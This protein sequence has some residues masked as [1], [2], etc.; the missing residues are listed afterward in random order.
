MS[1]LAI[2]SRFVTPAAVGLALLTTAS[3]A[4]AQDAKPA[5]QTENCRVRPDGQAAPAK[6]LTERLQDCNSVL[7]PKGLGDADIVTVPPKVNDPMAI[8]P[9]P[10]VTPVDPGAGGANVAPG[11]P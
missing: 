11:S 1:S 5:G 4:P 7:Q 8:K 10:P 2:V 9:Q 6:L 3:D